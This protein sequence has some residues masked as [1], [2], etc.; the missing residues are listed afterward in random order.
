MESEFEKLHE[1]IIIGRIRGSPMKDQHFGSLA[2]VLHS[3]LP[4]VLYHGTWPHGM[5]WLNEAAA[6]TYIP[7]LE[8]LN[9]LKEEGYTPHLTIGLTSVLVDQLANN[10]FI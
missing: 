7:L 6:E 8:V 4:Y 1:F 9:R 3:H 5:S 10:E 2:I